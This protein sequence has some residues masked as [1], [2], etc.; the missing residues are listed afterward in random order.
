M[1]RTRFES[2]QTR[3]RGCVLHVAALKCPA[4]AHSL[5]PMFA[6]LADAA[7]DF[8]FHHHDYRKQPNTL[9]IIELVECAAPPPRADAYSSETSSSSDYPDSDDDSEE[10]CSSYCSSDAP[11]EELDV[12]DS[13]ALSPSPDTYNLRMKRILAWRENFCPAMSAALDGKHPFHPSPMPSA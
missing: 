5:S 2:G 11:P 6:P 8:L 12:A 4:R 1:A 7:S 10:I 13:A 3:S 9:Q